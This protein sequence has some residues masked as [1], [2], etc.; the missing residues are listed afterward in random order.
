MGGYWK[1]DNQSSGKLAGFK[2][3]AKLFQKFLIFEIH[4]L[5]L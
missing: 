3:F 4:P 5:Y 2:I 1:Y